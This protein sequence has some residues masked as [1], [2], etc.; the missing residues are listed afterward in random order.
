VNR[1]GEG[2]RPKIRA[3]RAHEDGPR[4]AIQAALSIVQV[5]ESLSRR[6]EATGDVKLRVRIGIHTG[7]VVVGEMGAAERLE[8]LA[9]GETPNLASRIQGVAEPGSVV[10]SD[11]TYRLTKGYFNFRDL[12]ARELKGFSHVTSLYEITAD[13]GVKHRLDVAAERELTPFIGREKEL[14][15]VVARWREALEGRFPVVTVCRHGL[16]RAWHRQVSPCPEAARARGLRG[17]LRRR[18]LRL[19]HFPGHRASVEELKRDVES[20]QRGAWDLPRATYTAGSP[21]VL[22]GDPGNAAFVIVEGQC[23]AYRVEGDREVELRVMGPGDVF[24]ETAVFSDK[25]RTASV[26]AVTDVVV[27]V[28]TGEVLSSAIGLNSWMGAFVRALADRFREVD[29]RLRVLERTHRPG[30]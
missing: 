9:I 12:G 10:V 1:A 18:V 19:D 14:A 28:V 29:E 4:R 24:G 8:V 22:E 6:F 30:G 25:P 20:F 21:I 11:A 7:A 13:A 27:V 16:R 26:K 3:T 15:F 5:M 2:S 17:G 23:V